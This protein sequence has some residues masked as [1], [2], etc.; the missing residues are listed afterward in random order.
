MEEPISFNPFDNDISKLYKWSIEIQTPVNLIYVRKKTEDD[1]DIETDWNNILVSDS[2]IFYTLDYML[3]DMLEN[4]YTMDEIY[5]VVK[6][7][8]TKITFDDLLY[9]YYETLI[10]KKA[11]KQNLFEEMN[12]IRSLLTGN[13]YSDLNH[14]KD[15]YKTWEAKNK[16]VL[17]TTKQNLSQIVSIQKGLIEISKD[18][19]DIM[20]TNPESH[21]NTYEFSPKIKLT[22][23]SVNPNDGIDIF[24]ASILSNAI[25]FIKYVEEDE[26]EFIK[27]H[28]VSFTN[29]LPIYKKAIQD[30]SVTRRKNT[31]YISL[32]TGT[33]SQLTDLDN[34]Q[35]FIKEDFIFITYKLDSNKIRVHLPEHVREKHTE[36]EL[37]EK[38][39]SSF[40][41]LN[42][43]EAKQVQL[44]G[45]FDVF[46][47]GNRMNT[48]DT[49]SLLDYITNDTYFSNYI[50]VEEKSNPFPLKRRFDIHYSSLKNNLR[51]KFGSNKPAISMTIKP[52]I[53]LLDKKGTFGKKTKV[54]PKGTYY[55]HTT[56]S[57]AESE[58]TLNQFIVIFRALMEH[59]FQ[60]NKKVYKTYA[61]YFP[62][63]S[64]LTTFNEEK[65]V[66][67]ETPGE[68]KEIEP[69]E[70]KKGSENIKD[71]HEIAPKLFVQN[72]ARRCQ[73]HSQPKIIP[74]DEVEAWKKKQFLVKTKGKNR[75]EKYVNR[76]VM[77]FPDPKDT[78]HTERWNF[79]CPNDKNPYPGLK[80]NKD[81]S[82]KDE[83]P[84]IICCYT[85]DN[86]TPSDKT[87]KHKKYQDYIANIIPKKQE[88]TI[89]TERKINTR[90]ILGPG[91]IGFL[92]KSMEDVFHTY[93]NKKSNE[94]VRLGT[95][96]S[97][98]SLLHC[99][100]MAIRDPNYMKLKST[101]E[102]EK[103]VLFL[104]EQLVN[105][106]PV[107]V[108]YQELYDYSPKEIREMVKNKEIFLDPSLF[109]R[110]IE[111][112]YN[113][114]IYT[115][116][117]STDIKGAEAITAQS[118][119][120][121]LLLPRH[122]IYHYRPKRLYRH[123]ILIMRSLGADTDA[124]EYPQCELIVNNYKSEKDMESLF[125]TEMTSTCH[126]ILEDTKPS[127]TWSVDTKR[128]ET[129]GRKNIYYHI[130]YP[131]L[132]PYPIIHQ[133]IDTYGKLRSIT[134][135]IEGD[136]QVTLFTLPSQPFLV[137]TSTT[138]S[139][140]SFDKAKQLFGEPSAISMD[141]EDKIQGL[142]FPVLDI[143][144]AHYV[145][146]EVI[147]KKKTKLASD[148]PII[149]PVYTAKNKTTSIISNIERMKRIVDINIQ[150]VQWCYNIEKKNKEIVTPDIFLNT[151]STIDKGYDPKKTP[152]YLYYDF[153][154]MERFLP[155]VNTVPQAIKKMTKLGTNLFKNG[156]IVFYN[157]L[158]KKKMYDM[159]V[160]YNILY[161]SKHLPIPT[162]LQ[163]YYVKE[164]DFAPQPHVLIFTST[165]FL[166]DW[167]YSENNRNKYQSIFQI[168]ETL[169]PTSRESKEP[170]L[171][172]TET[173]HYYLVQNIFYGE[174]KKESALSVANQWYSKAINVGWVDDDAIEDDI[175]D[176]PHVIYGINNSMKIFMM[177]DNTGGEENFLEILY[178]GSLVEYQ[179]ELPSMYAALLPIL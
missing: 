123:S 66:V 122:N 83:F 56:V 106:V 44:T 6:K 70:L 4:G 95:P 61:G 64:D 22:N 28:Q 162:F 81:L 40:P 21:S 172:K 147:P 52:E 75:E 137:P 107:E 144:F 165:K 5:R 118:D 101:E 161:D 117:Y 37:F 149:P 13:T 138:V 78:K 152:S 23:Q 175:L 113:I 154:N 48:L 163:R 98:N 111:E 9:T 29:P 173:N 42:F 62:F 169:K 112:L 26:K 60:G 25:P 11:K 177:E 71:L 38:L 108:M 58:S 15:A 142:W 171:Y 114:N 139:Y 91:R 90:K 178:Y 97:K 158:Y 2:Y 156:K 27:V 133:T 96:R 87:N 131:A 45:E 20:I 36:T 86:M 141:N 31:I 125:D 146:I 121:Q 135:Q 69:S 47:M 128:V 12:Q 99:V 130:D 148:I 136:S 116:A 115:F 33:E 8:I 145:P 160:D 18:R 17:V 119:A 43:E 100:S 41:T 157:E 110:A 67:E 30:A 80:V 82:N 32:W 89:K 63:L 50:Y 132:I 155:N 3:H 7:S 153:D 167:L 105:H 1:V 151:Y 35:A 55:I 19:H 126:R 134:F 93:K 103:Y 150:L 84:Y 166:N 127:I 176:F 59:Y 88:A 14:I 57:Q 51:S 124:L 102:R 54:F 74:N 129:F 10:R 104:R 73:A 34:T 94:F 77:V 85:Q 164:S 68:K 53:V 168:Q 179:G 109:Y 92:P 174:K 143:P 79:V 24:N 46:D 72:Y 140:T 39:E 120:G 76:Q 16:N 65:K 49:T 159:L 170:F